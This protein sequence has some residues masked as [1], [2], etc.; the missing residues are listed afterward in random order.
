[1]IFNLLNF[2]L[3]EFIDFSSLR[4]KLSANR[5]KAPSEEGA[6]IKTERH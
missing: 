6:F 3:H 4:E 1:M 5:K 2:L